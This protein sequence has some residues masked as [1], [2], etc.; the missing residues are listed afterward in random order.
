MIDTFPPN[1]HMHE[2]SLVSTCL[3]STITVP[4]A[5]QEV[6]A[7]T[8]GCGVSVPKAADVA[9]ATA[10]FAS[11]EHNPQ[12]PIFVTPAASVTIPMV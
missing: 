10:G 9:A 5:S 2:H 12:D 8:Q 11:D 6:V 7:G 4:V 3:P 1:E